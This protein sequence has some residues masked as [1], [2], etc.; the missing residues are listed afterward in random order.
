MERLKELKKEVF[1]ARIEGGAVSGEG[2]RM[3]RPEKVKEALRRL[4][5]HAWGDTSKP[6]FSIPPR[7]EVDADC[8][9]YDYIA[10]LEG[11][12]AAAE[13]DRAEVAR[14]APHECAKKRV[15]EY[16][17]ASAPGWSAGYD[18]GYADGQRAVSD[19]AELADEA[20]NEGWRCSSRYENRGYGLIDNREEACA[21]FLKKKGLK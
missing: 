4:C 3:E 6:V 21:T 15:V 7:P 2:E 9:V 19:L 10:T 11:R 16:R 1:Q 8:I 12:L 14:E 17:A 13:K 5:D 20:F 18:E